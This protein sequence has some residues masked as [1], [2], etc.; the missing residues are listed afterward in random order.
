MSITLKEKAFIGA[1]G[2]IMLAMLKLI[3]AKFFLTNNFTSI[4]S[5]VGYLTYF[6][7]IFLGLVTAIYFTDQE[8][9][10]EKQKKHSFILGLLAPSLLI[11]IVNQPLGDKGG[12]NN[13]YDSVTEKINNIN[14]LQNI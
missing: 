4:D 2:G 3:E 14:G 1:V 11:A 7:F 5:L 6:C 12:R 9:P 10:L 8:A 13:G